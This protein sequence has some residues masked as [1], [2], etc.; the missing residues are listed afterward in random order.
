MVKEI[1]YVY[2]DGKKIT[3]KEWMESVIAK[4]KERR[5]KKRFLDFSKPKKTEKKTKEISIVAEQIENLIKPMTALKSLQV[6]KTH[7]YRSWGTI[8]NEIFAHK[9]ISKPMAAFCVNFGEM[10]RLINNVQTMATKNEKA[11]YQ[12]IDK[13]V[14]KLDDM[15]QNI[16]EMLEAVESSGICERF[17]NHEAIYGK[18]RQLGLNTVAKKC[19]KTLGNLEETMTSLKKIADNGTDPF[20]YGDHMSAKQRAR[21]KLN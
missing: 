17:K 18:G 13:L 8:A 7:A 2:V 20:S 4:Q 11:A 14:W 10:N 16:T 12:Y 1:E 9:G 3:K 21:L 5:G 15:K 19:L 6:Y